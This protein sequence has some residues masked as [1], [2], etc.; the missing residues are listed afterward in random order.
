LAKFAKSSKQATTA[1]ARVQ[2][3]GALR[4]VGTTRGYRDALVRAADYAKAERIQGGLHALTRDQVINYLE[5]RGQLVGQKTLDL[6]RQAVQVFLRTTGALK[7]DERLPVIKSEMAQVLK[8]RAYTRAQVD[9]VAKAQQARNALATQLASAAGLRAHELLTLRPI[10]ERNPDPRPSR[11]EKFFGRDPGVSYTVVGK[12]GLAREVLLPRSLAD[13][14]EARRLA[15]PVRVTDRGI[16]YQS[17]YDV[18][19][20]HTWSQSYSAASTRALGWSAGAHGVRH[21]YAQSRMR[22]LQNL[23]L[24]RGEALQTVSQEM[25]HF[26]ADI[27]EVYLR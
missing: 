10:V 20:G 26:R 5:Q 17:H 12:G 15:E 27:T 18:A 16:F 6:D 9:L 8:S 13:Q 14:L 21:S 3:A 2:R 4:S 24:M 23:G 1:I 11:A 7:S 22:E 25:G 19:G